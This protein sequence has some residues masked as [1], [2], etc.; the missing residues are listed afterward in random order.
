MQCYRK[1][2]EPIA[3]GLAVLESKDVGLFEIV[4][5]EIHRRQGRGR[6]IVLGL[7]SWAKQQGATTAYLQV[8]ADNLPALKLYE[9]LGFTELY[10][11]F[12]RIQNCP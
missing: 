8:V 11:Y 7:L 12:Y 10:Q 9:K 5:R 3:V 4:T 6:S 1:E 2:D